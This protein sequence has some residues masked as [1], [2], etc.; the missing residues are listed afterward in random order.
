VGS[1]LWGGQRWL[2]SDE[3]AREVYP[4]WERDEWLTVELQFVL[5]DWN[6][7]L[8][9]NLD[10]VLGQEARQRLMQGLDEPDVGSTLDG[11]FRWVQAILKRLERT[12]SD[13]QAYDI[14]SSCAHVFPPEQIDKLRGV[15]VD[16][17]A[18]TEDPLDAV[19][20]V[21]AFMEE[22][23]GWG[24]AP[25]RE[26][27]IVYSTKAPRDLQTYRDAQTPAEARSAY[28]YCPIVRNRLAHGMPASFCYCGAGWLRQQWEGA[29]GRPVSIS[30]VTS[31][32]RGHDACQFAI[33]LPDDLGMG[34]GE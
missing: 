11:R 16:A 10:R 28:C 4:D 3:F 26:G 1:A 14:L 24:Q 29:I 17:L 34:K 23:P 18:S 21:I 8:K 32:L 27:R 30:I 22:D 31:V 2:I 15:Y 9:A 13:D 12:A 5:H 6:R 25:R 7:L 20:A 19:D 33:Q